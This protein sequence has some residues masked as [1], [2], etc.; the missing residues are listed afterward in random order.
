MLA[1]ILLKFTLEL[2]KSQAIS[3][4][5]FKFIAAADTVT[6]SL[7]FPNW[8][9]NVTSGPSIVR[10]TENKQNIIIVGLAGDL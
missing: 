10:V 9:R 8:K 7:R 6:V 4:K 1:N 3:F 2:I 5:D